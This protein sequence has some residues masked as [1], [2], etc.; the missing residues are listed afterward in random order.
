MKGKKGLIQEHNRRKGLRV[1]THES[2]FRVTVK[3]TV[4]I[5]YAIHTR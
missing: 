1:L 2:C 4:Q 5:A 3:E